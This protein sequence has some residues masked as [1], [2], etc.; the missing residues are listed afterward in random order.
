V[1][2]DQAEGRAFMDAILDTEPNC[3]D[4]SFRETLYRHAG[5]IQNQPTGTFNNY[6]T[7]IIGPYNEPTPGNGGG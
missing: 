3:L 5:G 7:Y 1:D 6:G 2:R 4:E